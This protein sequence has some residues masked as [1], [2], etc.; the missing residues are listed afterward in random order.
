MRTHPSLST[1]PDPVAAQLPHVLPLNVIATIA[2]AF[3]L[4]A[5]ANLIYKP[6]PMIWLLER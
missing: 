3:S 4:F 1:F 5:V 2:I 6:M